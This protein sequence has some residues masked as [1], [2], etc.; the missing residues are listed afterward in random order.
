MT[1]TRQDVWKLTRDEGDWPA[2]LV[3]YDQAVGVLRD[4]TPDKPLS[5][6]FLAAMHGLAA[7]NGRPDTS[8]PLWSNCQHGSWFFLAWHRMYLRAFE[9][10]I[11]DALGDDDWSLPYWYA[12]DPDDPDTSILPPAFLDRTKNLFTDKRSAPANGGRRLPDLSQFLVEALRADL[13]STATGV[14]TFGGGERDRPSFNGEEVGLLE[15]A[16]HGGVH[17]YVGNDYDRQGRPVRRGWMGSFYTAALDPIFWLHHSNIDRLWQ[18]WL[19]LDPGNANPTDDPTW[20]DTE[21]SFPKV[22]GGLHTWSIGEVL[23][24]E[25]IGYEYA[26]TAPP[27]AVVPGVAPPVAGVPDIGLEEVAVPE[28]LPPQVIGT[29]V[30]VPIAT[31]EAVGVELAE[32]ADLGLELAAGEPAGDGRVFLRVEGVTGT[33]AAGVYEVYLNVPPGESPAEHPELLAGS[34]STFGLAEASQRDDVHDGSG[35]T[36][37]LDVTSV[38]DELERADRWDPGR[39]QVSFRPVAPAEAPEEVEAAEGEPADLR[40]SAISVVVT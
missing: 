11:Q 19:D 16:P 17:S 4:R 34:L 6:T 10:A 7:P 33:A 35:L 38:R 23:D 13:F 37:V 21:F 20:V 26:S 15:G 2:V 39:L 9:L 5:W 22:G 27:S 14:S 36:T 18:V 30:D 25:T 28:P 1:R 40:A 32:P 31:S 8:N 29:T 3:A 12:V 24:L